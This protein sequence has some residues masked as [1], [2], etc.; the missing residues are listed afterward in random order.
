MKSRSN[1][2]SLW[3]EKELLDG[4]PIDSLVV[5]LR[6]KG[7]SWHKQEGCLM[8]GYHM[9]SDPSIMD[10]DVLA[11]VKT[12]MEKLDGHEIIKMYISGSFFN[13]NEIS[14]GL[15][16]DILETIGGKVKKLLVESRPEFISREVIEE[17][18]GFVSKLEVAIG[19]ESANDTVSKRCVNKGFTFEDYK[20]AAGIAKTSGASVRT[21]LLV[22]PP[23]LTEKEAI[24]D[25][26]ESARKATPFSDVISFNPVNV[27]RGTFIEKLWTKAEYRPPW[28]WSVIEVL[29]GSKDL[30]PRIVCGPSG[31]GTKRGAH[32]CGSCDRTIL[33]AIDEFSIR[34]R[35]DFKEI[36]CQCKELWQDILDLEF[37][38]RTYADSQRISEWS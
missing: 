9:D 6:T 30:G 37:A 28:L 16:R 12:A 25:A 33:R 14:D 27:Q 38:M 34:N 22:K 18:L 21:Y 1:P 8:C 3:T 7:C 31:G 29:E 5:I 32:N 17:T 26:L 19:L 11:Q 2:V 23:F 24:G 4:R 10:E 20:K 13:E 15:R 36:G 35:R